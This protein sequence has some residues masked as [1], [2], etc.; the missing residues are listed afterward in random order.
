[1]KRIAW[2]VCAL[3]ASCGQSYGQELLTSRP[4]VVA[5]EISAKQQKSLDAWLKKVGKWKEYDQKWYNQVPRDQDGHLFH[6]ELVPSSPSWVAELCGSWY[7]GIY[8]AS[9]LAQGC[10]YLSG[11][12]FYS[13]L[14]AKAQEIANNIAQTRAQHEKVTHSSFLSRVHVDTLGTNPQVGGRNG[15]IYGLLG[16]HIS[17]VDAGRLQFFGPPGVMLVSVETEAGNRQMR[18]GYTWG[19]SYR[20]GDFHLPVVVNGKGKNATVFITATKVWL[21]GQA[22]ILNSGGID[23]VSLSISPKMK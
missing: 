19:M 9:G 22:G 13:H 17:L 2:L 20:M 1:M 12:G 16:G 14:D 3:L 18:I 11:I 6:R 23:F 5:G 10:D 8:H 21:S 15:R 4:I 7:V